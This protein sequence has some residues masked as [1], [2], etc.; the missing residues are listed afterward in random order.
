MS[1]PLKTVPPEI[2]AKRDA[3]KRMPGLNPKATEFRIVY[4]SVRERDD[5]VT[6]RTRSG[7][8]ILREL[9]SFVEAPEQHQREHRVFPAAMVP[10]DGQEPPAANG[11]HVHARGG[12]SRIGSGHAGRNPLA[13]LD[14]I[15]QL[16]LVL[17]LWSILIGPVLRNTLRPILI[18]K[19][20][21]LPP[22]LVP[23]GVLGGLTAS[24][25]VGIFIGP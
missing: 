21:D 24:G 8:Q 15:H 18:K 10:P 14:G 20:A 3:I 5:V 19:G 7:M 25:L 22:R 11:N 4:G 6:I 13:V 12:A 16:W 1:F 17:L 23:A 2:Q 9:S